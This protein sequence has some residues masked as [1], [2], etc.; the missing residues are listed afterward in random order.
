VLV[1]SP[2]QLDADPPTIGSASRTLDIAIARTAIVFRCGFCLLVP[3]SAAAVGSATGLRPLRDAVVLAVLTWG[4]IVLLICGRQ[5]R[6]P[7][8]LVLIDA[9]I[10]AAIALGA[11]WLL[12]DDL[13]GNAAAWVGAAVTPSILLA[14]WG[15]R[16]WQSCVVLIAEITAYTG[17][18]AIA[19]KAILSAGSALTITVFA[20]QLILGLVAVRFMRHSATAADAALARRERAELAF[21]V[22]T[23]RLRDADAQRLALHDTVLATLTAVARGCLAGNGLRL[24][25]RAKRDLAELSRPMAEGDQASDLS[26]V[27]RTTVLDA[28][29][30]GITLRCNEYQEYRL[31]TDVAEALQAALREALTNIER[32]A[33][34]DCASLEIVVNNGICMVMRDSGLGLSSRPGSTRSFGLRDSIRGRMERVGGSADVSSPPAGGTTVTLA[35]RPAFPA[36][37]TRPSDPYGPLLTAAHA[38]GLARALI[39]VAFGWHLLSLLMLVTNQGSYRWPIGAVG[40]WLALFAI[41][42]WLLQQDPRERIRPW[43]GRLVLIAVVLAAATGVLS[44]SDD[45]L[46]GSANWATGDV[47]WLL[48]AMA[49]QR[50]TREVLLA[51]LFIPLLDIW[52]VHSAFGDTQAKLGLMISN[53]L[54]ISLLQIGALAM[55]RILRRHGN[56]AGAAL[57]AVQKLETERAT[58]LA[59][60]ADRATRQRALEMSLLPLVR[61]FA[62]GSIDADSPRGR[63][64]AWVAAGTLRA[65]LEHE[66][67]HSSPAT[68]ESVAAIASAAARL[69][70]V[71]EVRVDD[72]HDLPSEVA[73]AMVQIMIK[74]LSVARP[75]DATLVLACETERATVTICMSSVASLDNLAEA[76]TATIG[77]APVLINLVDLGGN[78]AWLEATWRR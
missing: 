65:V 44:C 66:A 46:L 38:V 77:G 61:G 48:V 52:A 28:A 1:M 30:R 22:E 40:S 45:A 73:T 69:G 58:Q 78:R 39:Y 67:E 71:A 33:G 9:A 35:W 47:G 41:N 14:S 7:P 32:H 49:A 43:I 13:V 11:R 15:L 8:L 74:S 29:D 70:I 20:G 60:G 63:S 17:G 5:R 23:A 34:V 50:P 57:A 37:D 26:A 27:V 72:L 4:G 31:P 55:Y 76:A 42:L 68:A 36:V 6:L 59:V 19:G 10:F 2:P 64:E 24:R 3:I 21:S 62:D 16:R 51:M 56:V 18:L 75:T 12:P 54:V 25:N 53:L